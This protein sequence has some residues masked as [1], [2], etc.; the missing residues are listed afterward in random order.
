M[1]VRPS[2]GT[3]GDAYYNAMAESFFASLECEL[4]NRRSWKSQDEARTAAFVHS[5]TATS[6]AYSHGGRSTLMPS[7]VTNAGSAHRRVDLSRQLRTV[8]QPVRNSTS[9]RCRNPHGH[10][11]GQAEKYAY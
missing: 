7:T 6:C 1:G 4:I 8:M 9:Q 2:M 11:K 10:H 5:A 3:V